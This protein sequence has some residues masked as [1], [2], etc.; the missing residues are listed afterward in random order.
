MH[1]YNLNTIDLINY[2]N[3]IIGYRKCAAFFSRFASGNKRN[4][5]YDINEVWIII[6]M[7][8]IT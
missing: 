5:I 8:V 3:N 7:R 4:I 2:C 6:G 1:K